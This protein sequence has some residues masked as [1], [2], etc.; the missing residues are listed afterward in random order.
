MTTTGMDSSDPADGTEPPT[1]ATDEPRFPGA[2]LVG[3]IAMLGAGAFLMMVAV[4]TA[5]MSHNLNSNDHE[6]WGWAS[7]VV[8]VIAGWLFLGVASDASEIPA[9]NRPWYVTSTI[10]GSY[11]IA[12]AIILFTTWV[13][14]QF[15]YR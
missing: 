7:I 1:D 11:V 2:K 4:V 10:V 9:T 6:P 14:A 3:A 8:H 13:V 12:A 5:G 15:V